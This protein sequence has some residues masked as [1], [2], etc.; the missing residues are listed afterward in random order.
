MIKYFLLFFFVIFIVNVNANNKEKIINNLIKTENLSFHFEQ[1]IEGKIENGNCIIEYPK[2]IFCEYFKNKILVS[3]G[4]SLVIKTISGYYR[5]PLEKTT[6]N[7]LL[8]KIFL[9]D[10]INNLNESVLDNSYITYKISENSNEINIFFDKIT[11]DLVGW[12]TKD[13][14][15]NL[16]I[17][18]ISSIRKNQIIKKNLFKLPLP[19]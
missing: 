6:F 19:N 18:F 7:M 2:K 11:F 15:Q 9:I 13:I 17:T 5:Y 12:Q 14:Y 4:K 8:D 10:K 3:N 16:N 1:N